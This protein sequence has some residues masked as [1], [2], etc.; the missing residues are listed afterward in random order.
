[1]PAAARQGDSGVPHCSGYTIATGSSNVLINGR[2]AARVGDTSTPHLYPSGGRP[3]CKPHTASITSGSGTVFI[4]GR[5]AA[6]VG[7]GLGGC[8]AVGSGSFNVFIG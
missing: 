3:P 8:T 7:D 4:N 5:P 1:M 2:Q 6:R